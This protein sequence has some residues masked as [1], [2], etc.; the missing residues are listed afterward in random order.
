MKGFAGLFLAAGVAF[1]LP[2]PPSPPG[3][4]GFIGT[5]QCAQ[6]NCFRAVLATN[7]NPREQARRKRECS[8][9]LKTTVLGSPT[10]VVTQTCRA[11]TYTETVQVTV[12]QPTATSIGVE[13]TTTA[14]NNSSQIAREN[15]LT[16]PK[17][18]TLTRPALV[19]A[20]KVQDKRDMDAY[21]SRC[22]EENQNAS[23]KGDIDR[24]Q[25]L[26][27]CT[28][29]S[30]RSA[31]IVMQTSTQTG[32]QSPARPTTTQQTPGISSSIGI[33]FVTVT[34]T[35]T[36]THS[37]LTETHTSTVAPP[38]RT[39]SVPTQVP[40]IIPVPTLPI[41]IPT[42]PTLMP[43]PI[44]MPTIPDLVPVPTLPIPIPTVP[45][46]VPTLPVPP[47]T[48]P[49]PIPTIPIPV[50]TIPIPVPTIPIP[51]PTIPTIPIPIPTIPTI[52]IPTIPLPIPTIPVPVPTIPL[53][54]PTI[55]LPVPTIP[56]PVPTI[57]TPTIPIPTQTSSKTSTV[58]VTTTETVTPSP[59]S[60]GTT[61]IA[62]SP[63]VTQTV[64]A[65]QTSTTQATPVPTTTP[66]PPADEGNEFALLAIPGYAAGLC[67]KPEDYV[68]ACECYGVRP[69]V[70]TKPPAQAVSTHWVYN[71]VTTT[72]T[73]TMPGVPCRR[74]RELCAPFATVTQS[75]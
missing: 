12:Y 70:S 58:H 74:K 1:G 18:A 5:Y 25:L 10:S 48:V 43:P 67:T 33:P 16:A 38:L 66:P 6:D 42:M 50:P 2:Q 71:T 52:P 49:V 37:H 7:V 13:D 55:P 47:P 30:T 28:V 29:C 72:A 44:P 9:L 59:S 51:V 73:L 60:T 41:P 26:P 3:G 61:T 63:T 17:M 36:T 62:G 22:M 45:I 31:F 11:T 19:L 57:S 65:T 64:T 14:Q 34:T 24:R 39:P 68:S 4:T 20:T 56:V 23:R 35:F 32:T 53:P 69:Q 40:T 54:I 46:P 27:T 75:R 21:C 8:L 15:K